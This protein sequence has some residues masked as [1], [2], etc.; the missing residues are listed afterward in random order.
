M[1]AKRRPTQRCALCGSVFRGGR[2][3]CPEC[4]SDAETGW[5]SDEDLDHAGADIPDTFTDEDYEDVL[6]DLPGGRPPE[7]TAWDRRRVWVVATGILLLVVLIW[8]WV[9]P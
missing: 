3:A 1:S 4:G 5:R 9:L 2:L 6:R 8:A 7:L